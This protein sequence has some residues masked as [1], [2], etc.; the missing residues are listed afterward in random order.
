VVDSNI[1]IPDDEP[2]EGTRY[3]LSVWGEDCTDGLDN[4][5]DGQVDCVDIICD[6]VHPSCP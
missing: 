3:E 2:Q 4:D 6:G 5:G 1:S